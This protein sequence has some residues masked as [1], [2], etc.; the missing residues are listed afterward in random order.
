MASKHDR[1]VA[2]TATVTIDSLDDKSSTMVAW[3]LRCSAQAH[4]FPTPT[5]PQRSCGG[6]HPHPPRRWARCRHEDDGGQLVARMLSGVLI[7][8]FHSDHIAALNDVI[9]PTG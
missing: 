5:R 1:V 2:H 4:R 7:T 8:H 6:R 3:K 9:T